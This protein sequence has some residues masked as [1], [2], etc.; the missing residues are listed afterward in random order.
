MKLLQKQSA[1]TFKYNCLKQQFLIHFLQNYP[2]LKNNRS[3]NIKSKIK[4]N[5]FIHEYLGKQ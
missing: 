2:L 3:K 1:D 5:I 4:V